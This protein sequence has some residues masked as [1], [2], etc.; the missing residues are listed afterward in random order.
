MFTNGRILV[1]TDFSDCASHAYPYAY[2]FAKAYNGEVHFAHVIDASVFAIG[3]TNGLW[4]TAEAID[5]IRAG[6][7]QY[8]RNELANLIEHAKN[9]G[10]TAETHLEEGDPGHVIG[11]LVKQLDA[12]LVVISTHG[13]SG[14]EHIVFGSTSDHIVRHAPA[15]VLCV[16]PDEHDLVSQDRLDLEVKKVLF[17]TDFSPQA[18][19]MLPYAVSLCKN[20]GAELHLLYVNELAVLLPEYLPEVAMSTTID[21]AGE[22]EKNLKRVA[23]EIKEVT[24]VPHVRTGP[25]YREIINAEQE[26]EADLIVMPTHGRTGIAHVLFGSIAERVVRMAKCPVLA[27]KKGAEV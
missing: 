21:V 8:A 3:G 23:E 24:V 13:R 14:L 17:P 26:V 18:Q 20:F 6:M 9:N 25:A 2:A 4:T 5:E 22:S 7:T 15:P 12:G 16:R 10:V 1:A 19:E 27:V 11:D